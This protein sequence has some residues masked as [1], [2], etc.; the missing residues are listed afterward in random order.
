MVAPP[1]EIFFLQFYYFTCIKIGILTL[2]SYN[3]I[4]FKKKSLF[5]AMILKN[6]NLKL[7][8]EYLLMRVCMYYK[9]TNFK[10]KTKPEFKEILFIM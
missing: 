5:E 6:F 8:S 1:C 9:V 3:S 7:V 4:V 10:S 2:Q